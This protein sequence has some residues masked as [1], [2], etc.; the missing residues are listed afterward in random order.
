[1]IVSEDK[2]ERTKRT[3]LPNYKIIEE[4]KMV[5]YYDELCH[6]SLSRLAAFT[7]DQTFRIPS[8]D[9]SIFSRNLVM[10]YWFLKQSYSEHSPIMCRTE[11][12]SPHSLQPGLLLPSNSWLWESGVPWRNPKKLYSCRFP[13]IIWPVYDSRSLMM[14]AN[15]VVCAVHTCHIPFLSV[16]IWLSILIGVVIALS[17]R[18]LAASSASLKKE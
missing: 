4:S 14:V 6:I 16:N 9:L 11:I 10:L 12:G 1:M 2:I 17:E 18:S 13:Q 5:W 7:N 3:K 15:A 8:V